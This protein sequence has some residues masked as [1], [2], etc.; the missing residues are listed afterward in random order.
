MTI[1]LWIISVALIVLALLVI[2]GNLWIAIGGLFKKREKYESFIPF[3]GGVMGMIGLLLLPVTG[4]RIFFWL[5]L[6]VDLGCGPMLVSI[7]IE[8]IKKT[9]RG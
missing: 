4:A 5:P 9:L 2:I 8:Q 1:L 6:V 3:L 7:I